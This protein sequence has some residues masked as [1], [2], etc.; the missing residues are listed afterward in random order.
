MFAGAKNF[1]QDIGNW[2]TSA[3]TNMSAMFDSATAFN[4]PIGSW[5]ITAVTDMHGDSPSGQSCGLDQ[6]ITATDMVKTYGDV[7]FVSTATASSG[8][9][10][11]Y[12]SADNSIAEAFQDNTDGNKWKIKIK[13]AGQVN[14]TVKQPGNATYNPAADVIFKLTIN[15][16]ALTVTANALSKEYGTIDPILNLLLKVLGQQR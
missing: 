15:K 6:T 4:K 14:I 8:L 11:S 3:V 7:P 16:A 9:E 13:K 5:N 10:V 12:V 1:N 2:N